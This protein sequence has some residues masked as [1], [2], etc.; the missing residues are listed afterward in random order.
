MESKH[1]EEIRRSPGDGEAGDDAAANAGR[2]SVT[3]WKEE[4]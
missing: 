2:S 3:T 1:D 4:Q